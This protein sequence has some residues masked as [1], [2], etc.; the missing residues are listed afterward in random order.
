MARSNLGLSSVLYVTRL[1]EVLAIIFIA[2]ANEPRKPAC[3]FT[4]CLLFSVY[5]RSGSPPV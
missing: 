2:V 1:K 3:Q 5:V 4:Q